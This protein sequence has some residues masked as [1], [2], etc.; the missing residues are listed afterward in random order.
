VSYWIGDFYKYDTIPGDNNL[1]NGSL[2]KKKK[3]HC[4]P[5]STQVPR[6]TSMVI[7]ALAS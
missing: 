1:L 5:G 4:K 3:R 2:K 6:V 7:L